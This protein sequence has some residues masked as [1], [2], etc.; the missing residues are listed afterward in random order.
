[1]PFVVYLQK[2]PREKSLAK[3]EVEAGDPAEAARRFIGE[4]RFVGMSPS[5][6]LILF[7]IVYPG[8]RDD[9]GHLTGEPVGFYMEVALDEDGFPDMDKEIRCIVG[10]FDHCYPTGC[11]GRGY[12][13][14]PAHR[15]GRGIGDV[16]GGQICVAEN[17]ERSFWTTWTVPEEH[18]EAFGARLRTLNLKHVE[19]RY[20]LLDMLYREVEDGDPDPV[21]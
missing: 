18:R 15:Q 1:M 2:Y 6:P 4:C 11:F 17:E 7:I 8:D 20:H 14:W 3:G 21:S 19:G 12:I 9:N 16:V 13:P 5:T 10:P